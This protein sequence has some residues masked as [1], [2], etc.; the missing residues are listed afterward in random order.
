MILYIVLGFIAQLIDGCLGMAYGVFLT[1]V[2]MAQGV[3]LVSASSSIH[4]SEVFTTGA[5]C[6]SHWKFKNIDWKLFR[7]L[8]ISGVL[9]GIIGAYILSSVNGEAI[10]PVVSIYLLI[11]GIRI[12]L[13][14]RNKINFNTNVKHL[15]PLGTIG[16]FFDAIGGGGWGPIVTSSLIAKSYP[17]DK[18]IGSVN[19]AEFFVTLA[20]SIT[21]FTLIG[22]SNWKIVAGLIIGGIIA[23]PISAYLVKKINHKILMLLVALLIIITNCYSLYRFWGK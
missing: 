13:K 18:T 8:A 19:S 4:F 21:F 20:Q 2:L 11:L 17:P 5:S 16:G 9:G 12:L 1:T 3:P 10:K 22:L 7:K 6:I 15:I 23:A 14:V